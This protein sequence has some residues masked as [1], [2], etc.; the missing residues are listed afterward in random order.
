MSRR[1]ELGHKLVFIKKKHE[2]YS[3]SYSVFSKCDK[4]GRI[5]SF[6][7]EKMTD[8]SVK[9]GSCGG[10]K[11]DSQHPPVTPVPKDTVPSS[12]LSRHIYII[13]YD[14]K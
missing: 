9:K 2:T 4:L 6:E 8:S 3:F 12:V 7:A 11:F 13:I 14:E 10:P 1:L 5:S